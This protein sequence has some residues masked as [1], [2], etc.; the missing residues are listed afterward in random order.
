MVQRFT[1]FLMLVLFALPTLHNPKRSGT[2]VYGA[3]IALLALG[4]VS[5][6]RRHIWLQHLPKDQV[7]A[8]GPGLEYMLGNFPMA[9][10]WQEL[11]HGSGECAAKGWTFLGRGIPEWSLF[12]HVVL[13]VWAVMIPLRR[14]V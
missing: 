1:F 6:A 4:G 3:L 8:C 12:L 13:G 9:E 14:P 5:T 7:P 11:M 2:K 10:V